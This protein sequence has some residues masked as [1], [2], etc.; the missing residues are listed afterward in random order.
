MKSQKQDRR[1]RRTRQS[2]HDALMGLMLE[3]R[4][5]LITVQDIIDRADVGRST[6]YAHYRDKEDLLVSGLEHMIDTVSQPF[7]EGNLEN[8]QMILP[9]FQHVQEEHPRFKALVR[10]RCI[11][12]LFEKGQIYLGQ[13]IEAQ[14]RS[15]LPVGQEPSV[16]LPVVAHY[17]SSNLTALLKWWIDNNMPYSPER[18]SEIF[19]QLVMPGVWNTLE[20]RG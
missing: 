1:S 8:P 9:L 6:F 13:K 18:M 11:D 14:L 12:L 10:G 17:V 16:P 7:E 15:H 5:D 20:K 3:K 2:L 4:Y 19:Q